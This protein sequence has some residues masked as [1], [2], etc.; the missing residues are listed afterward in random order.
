MMLR[1]A[2]A[3]LAVCLLSAPLAAQTTAP[4]MTDRVL[5]LLADD[6]MVTEFW[7][8]YYA[9]KGAGYAVDVA[10]FKAG[11]VSAGRA[12]RNWA[13]ANL[14]LGDVDVRNYKAL[15]VPGGRSPEKLEANDLALGIC[16]RFADA[17]RPI[18]AICHGP[19]LLGSAG[20]LR[21]RFF[22][23]LFQ[24]ADEK[25]A[26][27]KAG[28]FG[29]YVD[30][31]VV[32]DRNLI[33]S[34]WP[35]D[36]VPFTRHLLNRL[37]ETGGR[38]R[39]VEGAWV[40]VLDLGATPHAGWAFGE[41]LE[42]LGARVERL[43]L[44][45]LPDA[46]DANWPGRRDALVVLEGDRKAYDRAR[47]SEALARRVAPFAPSKPDAKGPDRHLAG[48]G[49]AYLLL[50]EME[51][52]ST[53][54]I[55][56]LPAEP[57]EALAELL[58]LLPSR[59]APTPDIPGEPKAAPDDNR[60]VPAG[61]VLVIAD[62]FD[63]RV[64]LAARARLSAAL[65]QDVPVVGPRKGW[66]SGMNGVPLEARFSYDAPPALAEDAILI[67]PGGL[68]PVPRTQ[69][70][71]RVRWLLKRY[72]GGARLLTFGFDSLHVGK[73][74]AFAGKPI[75]TTEQAAWFFGD[76]GGKYARQPVVRSGRRF[77]S[78]RGYEQVA[79]AVKRLLDAEPAR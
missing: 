42:A 49:Q 69:R 59:T 41:A 61:A 15:V 25:P 32:V 27:W 68:W 40:T 48:L 65:G 31:P 24:V 16:G 19:R 33:T 71:E 58:A 18:A 5:F 2:P 46:P 34:R 14:A 21:G 45:D 56:K 66:L 29:H 50:A 54:A 30:Q 44:G 55:A 70:A 39:T 37:A 9:L 7:V 67:A 20:L 43:K 10:S 1:L 73:D 72:E 4:A 60:P 77:V 38:P 53:D 6:F 13:T 76:E 64:A 17:N 78:A 74:P 12:E 22:T 75:A 28:Y 63:G 51:H 26:L 23:C 3:V 52:L 57:D 47:K 36:V 35:A 8:P 62:G 11:P 79:E